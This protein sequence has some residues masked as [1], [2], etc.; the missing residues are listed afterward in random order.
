MMPRL[1]SI[2][3][4]RKLLAASM[5]KPSREHVYGLN[6]AFEV[7][8]AE[9]RRVYSA[10]LNQGISN[11]PRVK[12][13]LGVLER[14]DIGIQ[15][16]DKGRLM[17]LSGSRDHQGVVLKTSPYPYSAFEDLLGAPYLLLLDNVEDPH[18]VGAIL[19]SAEVFGFTSVCLPK[20]GVPEVYPSVVKVSAGAVEFMKICRDDSANGY[21]RKAAE[22]GYRIVALDAAGRSS[23]KSVAQSKPN[24][25]MLVIG[26]EDRSVGQFILNMAADVVGISQRG[27]VNSLNASVAAGIAMFALGQTE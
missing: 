18:N 13:L 15:W 17:Q 11:N 24:K 20:K 6:P 8:R 26:G 9:K 5:A 23:L 25:L 1:V 10:H 7:L 19:R 22:A 21:A 4:S 27:R 12:K 16:T 14:K 3:A 2:D